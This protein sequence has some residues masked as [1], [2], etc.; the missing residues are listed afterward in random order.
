MRAH[1]FERLLMGLLD[2]EAT[3]EQTLVVEHVEDKLINKQIT[4][5]DERVMVGAGRDTLTSDTHPAT[6]ESMLQSY[7]PGRWGTRTGERIQKLLAAISHVNRQR[8]NFRLLREWLHHRPWQVPSPWW[9]PDNG[10]QEVE[11][12][13][14]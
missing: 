10:S 14:L 8:R 2:K 5:F 6:I 9:H 4:A 3:F 7:D 11:L 12:I 1:P 13:E